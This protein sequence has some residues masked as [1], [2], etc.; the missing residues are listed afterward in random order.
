MPADEDAAKDTILV[1]E[2]E[3][4]IRTA[5]WPMPCVMPDIPS[6]S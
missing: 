3:P 6:S 1:V 5:R 2:D 4:L